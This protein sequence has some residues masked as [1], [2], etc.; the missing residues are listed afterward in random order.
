MDRW[1]LDYGP[2]FET[3]RG[4][5]WVLQP[6]AVE[7]KGGAA[8]ANLFA[9]PGGYVVPVVFGGP[10]PQVEVTV[11]GLRGR[12]KPSSCDALHPG[13]EEA[14]AI[15]WAFRNGE[16]RLAAPLQRGCAIL[17]VHCQDLSSPDRLSFHYF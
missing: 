8:K 2:L 10:A 13:V 5:K 12:S 9:V 1:Y 6:R 16:L 7:V 3:L 4:R 17:R 11:R 14:A 15:K